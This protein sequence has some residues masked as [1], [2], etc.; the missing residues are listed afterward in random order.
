MPGSDQDAADIGDVLDS[1]RRKEIVTLQTDRFSAERGQYGFVQSVVRQV[2]YA[3]LSRRDR[4]ARHVAA[5]DH[6]A[7][8][9]DAGDEFA[10]VIAQHLLDAVEG[11]SAGDPGGAALTARACTYWE[12]AAVRARRVGATGES[13]R[14]L[15][16]AIAHTEGDGDR[17]R[18][19]LSAAHVGDD[20]GHNAEARGHAEAALE[21]FDQV[22]DLVG[23]GRAAAALSYLTF[24]NNAAAVAIAEPRWLAPGRNARFGTRAL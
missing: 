3:T 22:H 8:L 12:K 4:T 10:V 14:L 9:P 21:L 15:E 7:G 18:L 5:A 20:A 2:A 1:L 17:A 13:Q 24:R 11:G 16:A 23:A 6:L 19:H